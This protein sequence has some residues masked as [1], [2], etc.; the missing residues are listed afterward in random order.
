MTASQRLPV[1][2]DLTRSVRRSGL[3]QAT[4]IDRVEHAYLRYVLSLENCDAF[5]LVQTQLGYLLVGREAMSAFLNPNWNENDK[6]PDWQS[7]IA[8]LKSPARART[9][10][11]LRDRSLGAVS[12]A[13]LSA[14]L[15]GAFPNGLDYYNVGHSN[16][17]RRTLGCVASLSGSSVTVMIHDTI[18]LDFPQFQRSGVPRRFKRRL[19]ASAKYASRIIT[20]SEDVR[21]GLARWCDEAPKVVVA[22]LGVEGFDIAAQ[23]D[24]PRAPYFVVLGTIEPRKNHTLLLDVWDTLIGG[25]DA[26]NMP[27]L[28][29]VGRRGWK[30][31]AYDNRLKR[32]R[33]RKSVVEIGDAEDETVAALMRGACGILHPS[34]AEGF[35]LPVFEAVALEKPV[36]ASP[37]PVFRQYLGDAII[38]ADPDKPYQWR[39]EIDRLITAEANTTGPSV[40]VRLPTWSEHF[41][42][43]FGF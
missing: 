1:C 20:G 27:T 9:E 35:G 39:E 22:P 33:A 7:K 26:S 18:P 38:Y 25:Y 14:M 43:A 36:I 23:I 31:D 30:T 40:K 13:R 24:L 15:R 19:A 29:V 37:L 8:A 34:F 11:F 2:L 10:T 21:N 41:S 6:S 5:G 12:R 17:T 4:G 32:M 16:L 28:I 3:R 42:I